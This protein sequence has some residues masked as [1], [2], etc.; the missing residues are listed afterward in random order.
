[1]VNGFRST[2]GHARVKTPGAATPVPNAAAL[3]SVIHSQCTRTSAPPTMGSL[4]SKS[5]FLF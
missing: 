1:M 3:S 5:S 2:F 4:T